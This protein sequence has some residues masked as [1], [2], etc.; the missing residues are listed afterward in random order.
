MGYVVV[1]KEE[2]LGI[3]AQVTTL[4]YLP[5]GITSVF[6]TIQPVIRPNQ[7]GLNLNELTLV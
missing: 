6:S 1:S 2:G 5:Y 4:P 3:V 7:D